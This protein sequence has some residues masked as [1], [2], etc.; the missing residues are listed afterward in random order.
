MKASQSI[1]VGDVFGTT[2]GGDV[3][4]TEYKSYREITV[5]FLDEHKHQ[6]VI[7]GCRLKSGAVKN[8]YAKTV[9][10]VA[11]IGKGA[12]SRSTHLEI[13]SRW[14]KIIERCYDPY[15]LNKDMSYVDV[16]VCDEWLNFQNFARWYDSKSDEQ[17]TLDIDKD[18]FSG[19]VKVYSPSTC[20]FLPKEINAFLSNC[21]KSEGFVYSERY[22]RYLARPVENGERKHMLFDTKKEASQFILDLRKKRLTELANKWRAIIGDRAYEKLCEA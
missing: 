11:Y 15:K 5:Q 2:Y 17:K 4:V 20:T 19:E 1:K 22:K 9:L 3:V 21:G 14:K 7:S 18:L 8:P 10:G 6:A 16:Y 13:Y 12:Y